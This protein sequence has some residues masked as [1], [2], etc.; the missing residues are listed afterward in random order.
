MSSIVEHYKEIHNTLELKLF[1]TL[2]EY[3]AAAGQILPAGFDLSDVQRMLDVACGSGK[4][5][6]D[7]AQKYPNSYV[8]GIDNNKLAIDFA[9]I[10]T[11]TYRIENAAFL[12]GDMHNM[13]KM[14]DEG[15]D[16][17]HAP[18]LAPAVQTQFWPAV[19]QELLRVCRP[20]GKIIWTEATF[21]TTNSR[22][23]SHWCELM[24]RAITQSGYTPNVTGYMERLLSDVHCSNL[25]RIETCIDISAGTALNTRIY[26]DIAELLYLIMPFLSDKK[27]AREQQKD[28]ICR[29]AVIDLYDEI[30]RGQW[31]LVTVTGEKSL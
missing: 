5:V 12:M 22:A 16:V 14:R 17:V 30:F 20:G 24:T 2:Q 26:Q 15:F 6:L 11:N 25:Q 13:E 4:W 1:R 18:F 8:I 7:V 31:T 27:V 9:N 19:L 28:D 21:P 29:E 3:L 10:L 23:C